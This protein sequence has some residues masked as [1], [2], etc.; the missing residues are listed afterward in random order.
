MGIF[1]SPFFKQGVEHMVKNNKVVLLC[2][3][4]LFMIP[5]ASAEGVPTIPD[6][7]YGTV[8]VNGE[9]APDG[10]IVSAWVDDVE[11]IR[12][13]TIDGKYG[14]V[15]PTSEEFQVSGEDG[16]EITFKIYDVVAETAILNIGDNSQL[17]LSA[18]GVTIPSDGSSSGSS[19]SGSS[20]GGRSRLQPITTEEANETATETA[21]ETATT[22]DSPNESV[23][24]T[25]IATTPE[26]E[27]P[28]KSIPVVPAIVGAIVIAIVIAY[29]VSRNK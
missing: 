24:E 11:V 4:V 18:T 29:L 16:I 2:V 10:T 3:L 21:A 17:D 12:Q 20:S 1:L 26:P 9:T 19:S 23:N 28:G 6:R 25:A 5:I 8:T 14:Y 7:F 22:I 27:T 15:P 13:A